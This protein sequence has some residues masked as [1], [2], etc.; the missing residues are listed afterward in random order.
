MGDILAM[1]FG[2]SAWIVLCNVVFTQ[3]VIREVQILTAQSE[4][5]AADSILQGTCD[6]VIVLDQKL[7]VTHGAQSVANMLMMTPSKI[8]G[9]S[10]LSLIATEEDRERFA[11][12]VHGSQSSAI[13]GPCTAFN[14]SLKDSAAISFNVEALCVKYLQADGGDESFLIGF[15]EAPDLPEI[16]FLTDF[17]SS[18]QR[19][20]H[21]LSRPLPAPQLAESPQALGSAR[22]E[23]NLAAQD[24]ISN[25]ASSSTGRS[26]DSDDACTPTGCRPPAVWFDP[27]S[28]DFELV[29]SS[30]EFR[31]LAGFSE[32]EMA[33]LAGV[34]TW[35]RNEQR[36]A[37]ASW[38][39]NFADSTQNR[40]SR[41]R[42]VVAGVK[43]CIV[44]GKHKAQF[45]A[46]VR[47][48][49]GW[50]RC[51]FQDPQACDQW[52]PNPAEDE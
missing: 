45:Q 17:S 44:Y 24:V 52:F 11:E 16:P 32:E 5:K 34:L 25:G 28:R 9:E 19:S 14:T 46:E 48:E 27:N 2:T 7:K 37:F 47:L 3:G 50:V 41:N 20:R 21:P 35:V 18:A 36:D 6:A 31:M 10:V 15:R 49:T 39:R 51:H 8:Q 30:A 4:L 13:P 38:V 40:E 33:E 22:G 42:D 26:S 43:F 1:W 12:M 23:D 29:K